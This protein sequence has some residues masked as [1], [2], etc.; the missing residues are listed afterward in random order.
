MDV[1]DHAWVP[2]VRLG[3]DP[4]ERSPFTYR[5]IV[6]KSDRSVRV[7]MA[8][9][10]A[11]EWIATRHINE[12]IGVLILQ[13]GDYNEHTLLDPLYKSCLQYTRMLLPDDH[14]RGARIR[15][16]TEFGVLYEMYHHNVQQIIFI[17]HGA[18]NGIKFGNENI[19][20]EKIAEILEG[21]RSGTK[22]VISLCC[23]NGM[24][25]F[26][27]PLSASSAVSGVIAPFQS[28][29]GCVSSLFLQNFLNERVL[30]NYSLKVAFKKARSALTGSASFKLWQHGWRVS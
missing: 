27:S 24:K 14:V 25:E 10:S 22:D 29:H 28:V 23:Q 7:S 11:S 3:E 20:S 30:Y 6:E 5:E 4:N 16:I 9:G 8:D 17:G 12:R 2:K 21:Q 1:G 15:T 13:I 18:S 19:K 26:S